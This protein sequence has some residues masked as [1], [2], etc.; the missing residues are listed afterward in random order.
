MK[1][2]LTDTFQAMANSYPDPVS[3]LLDLFVRFAN[4]GT[5]RRHHVSRFLF[6]YMI[7][8]PADTSHRSPNV[9]QEPYSSEADQRTSS[10][11]LLSVKPFSNTCHAHSGNLAHSIDFV[12]P[13]FQNSTILKMHTKNARKTVPLEKTRAWRRN[14]IHCSKEKSDNLSSHNVSNRNA[15]LSLLQLTLLKYTSLPRSPAE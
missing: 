11:S 14:I 15:L 5:R 8:M 7:I 9:A 3:R 12:T 6:V 13:L 4:A 2:P 1:D 10:R